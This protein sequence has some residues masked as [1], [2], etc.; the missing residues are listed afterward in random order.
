M[1]CI[2]NIEERQQEVVSLKNQTIHRMVGTAVLIAVVVVLQIFAGSI[3]IGTV[4]FTLS[5]I[6]IVLGAA[7]YGGVSGAVLGAAFGV[8]TFIACANG[9]DPGGNTLFV[10][11]AFACFLV[12]MVKGTLAGYSAG[13]V[14]RQISRRHP[15][16]GGEFAA[17]IAAAVTAPVVNTGIFCLSMPLFFMETLR[18]WADGSNLV[19]YVL[20][21]FVGINFLVELVVNLTLSPAIATTLKALR[22]TQGGTV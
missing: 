3:K 5:L 18:A 20:I 14:Y 12:C 1:R 15:S 10:A 21:A 22:K 11:N 19:S 4:S 2:C 6:P 13:V 9:T 8:I 16:R 7:F 17:V